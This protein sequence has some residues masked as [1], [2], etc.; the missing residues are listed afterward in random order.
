MYKM[1]MDQVIIG[2]L[3]KK[4][5]QGEGPAMKDTE[6]EYFTV[7]DTVGLKRKDGKMSKERLIVF[8]N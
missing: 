2:A 1:N 5:S 6:G 8:I 3:M 4:T 7:E